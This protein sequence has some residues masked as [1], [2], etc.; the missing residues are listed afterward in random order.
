MIRII[1]KIFEY[2]WVLKEDFR[3]TNL[4]SDLRSGMGLKGVKSNNKIYF[5]LSNDLADK[6]LKQSD[7]S[8]A[9]IYTGPIDN[10]LNLLIKMELSD[11]VIEDV[12]IE[13]QFLEYYTDEV[14]S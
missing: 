13:H 6:I 2:L 4:S 10:L 3:I 14:T 12:S 5:E 9:M 11:L 1:K 7:H 8:I